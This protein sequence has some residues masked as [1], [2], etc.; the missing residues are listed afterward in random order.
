MA[1]RSH[2]HS[3]L[4][5]DGFV[6]AVVVEEEETSIVVAPDSIAADSLGCSDSTPLP[7]SID[8]LLE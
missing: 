2:F 7:T 5:D 4:T 8:R 3:S 6:L 1:S